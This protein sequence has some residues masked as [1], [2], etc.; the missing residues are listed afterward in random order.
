MTITTHRRAD[1]KRVDLA[2]K[3]EG[4]RISALTLNQSDKRLSRKPQ[5]SAAFPEPASLFPESPDV[6]P[7]SQNPS[8]PPRNIFGNP[9]GNLRNIFGNRR[10]PS[11]NLRNIFG[12]LRQPLWSSSDTRRKSS[13]HLR[14]IFG[15][16]SEIL[17]NHREILG[18]SSGKSPGTSSGTHREIFDS[19][20][21]FSPKY[22]NEARLFFNRWLITNTCNPSRNEYH[23]IRHATKNDPNERPVTRKPQASLWKPSKFAREV[24]KPEGTALEPLTPSRTQSHLEF[25]HNPSKF[26]REVLPKP[27]V[28]VFQSH[29]SI[30]TQS[31]AKK[32]PQ[33]LAAHVQTETTQGIKV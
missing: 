26:A 4:T 1:R 6:A 3:P 31:H 33:P 24:S 8:G 15:N 11:G 32:S 5:I 29:T 20:L 16:P 28:T 23:A 27:E 14:E 10:N 17:R 12:N 18:T 9:S 30:R 21:Y 25:A 19:F 22:Q 7:P 2:P 13:E